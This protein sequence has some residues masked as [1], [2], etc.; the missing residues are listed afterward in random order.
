MQED[1]AYLFVNYDSHKDGRARFSP[2]GP[3]IDDT[4]PED[5][6]QRESIEMRALVFW[7]N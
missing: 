7:D 3:I 2:H 1:E 5:A 4:I 6:P